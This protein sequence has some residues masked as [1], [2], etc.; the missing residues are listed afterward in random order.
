[1]K[2]KLISVFSI[3]VMLVTFCSCAKK[4]H[5]E[6]KLDVDSI[7]SIDFKKTIFSD[8]KREHVQKSVTEQA[9]IKQ[10]A[11]WLSGL[12]LTEHEAI[13]IPVEKI[14]Y[15]LVI[16]GK[17]THTVIFMD[18]YIIYD[19]TAYTFDKSSDVT[20]VE[21]KYNLLG[22]TETETKLDLT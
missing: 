3:V 4:F 16:N 6:I 9:D 14:T 11:D 22:Y 21:T 15:A 18:E 12:R 13:E 5:P 2:R 20:T 17:K 7:T 8:D 19:F 10:L 1:M